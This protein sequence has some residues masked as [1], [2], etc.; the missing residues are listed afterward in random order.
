MA[1]A[2]FL[3]NLI[4]LLRFLLTIVIDRPLFKQIIFPVKKYNWAVLQRNVIG[5]SILKGIFL[6][7]DSK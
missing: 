1:S 4:P 2:A 6:V 7:L 3:D 5:A